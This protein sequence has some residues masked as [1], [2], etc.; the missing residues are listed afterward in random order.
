MAGLRL[1]DRP[2]GN[3]ATANPA[4]LSHFSAMAA[5]TLDSR[6]VAAPDQVSTDLAGQTAI[7]GT[8]RRTYYTLDETGTCVWEALRAPHRVAELVTLLTARYEVAP[9]EC[10]RDLLRFLE[11]LRAQGLIDEAP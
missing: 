5:L 10:A 6:V 3:P 9:D 2:P 1:G 11:E 7:L 8:V 4:L